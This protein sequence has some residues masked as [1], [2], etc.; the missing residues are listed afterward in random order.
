V[1]SRRG[2]R[3]IGLDAGPCIIECWY[4]GFP[5]A[6]FQTLNTSAS[7]YFFCNS[8]THVITIYTGHVYDVL[9]INALVLAARMDL[10]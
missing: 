6:M 9:C 10:D 4:F 1:S 2:L 5:S 3:I 7:M 8:R